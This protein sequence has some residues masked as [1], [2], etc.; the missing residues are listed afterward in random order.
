MSS[1][2]FFIAEGLTGKQSSG[3]PQEVQVG[4]WMENFRSKGD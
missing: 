3:H 1:C 4:R 2:D